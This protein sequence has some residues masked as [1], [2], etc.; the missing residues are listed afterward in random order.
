[1]AAYP[2]S[3]LGFGDNVVDKYEHIK[4]MYPGGNAVNF[5]VFAKKL[6]VDRSA[7]MGIFGSDE[8]AEHVIASL[9]D[10]GVELLRCQQVL[11]VN[12]AARVTVDETGDRIFL[13]SNEGGIRGDMRYVIDRF[14]AE[15]VSGFDLVHS[16]NYCFTE[17]E[18]PKIKAAG[19]PISFDFSDDSTDEYFGQIAPF[20]TYAFMS[21]GD[22]SLEDIKAKLE[23]VKALGP[24]IVCASRG[25]KGSV[26]YDGENFYEQGIKP[27][28]PEELKDAMAAGDSL[29]TAF[30]VTYL[31]KKKA[32]ECGK[33]A[34][35]ETGL[36]CRFCGGDLQDRG[37]L[38]PP[39]G[40]RELVFCRGGVSWGAPHCVR[41]QDVRSCLRG[42]I[43]LRR[44]LPESGSPGLHPR[45]P[46]RSASRGAS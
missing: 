10:E 43:L 37:Q 7:Y 4:T 30:L 29:L 8:E 25:S 16:G 41:S 18:L 22:A 23:W 20:V 26:A 19:V 39:A 38:G 31:S 12:G 33:A 42:R 32:G 13:G 9:E 40:L 45:G 28:A 44:C 21:M 14:A 34:I 5:A 27:V 36:R 15:Y 46:L 3:V 11:G 2:I 24:Q 1:M 35:R 6:G 17:R